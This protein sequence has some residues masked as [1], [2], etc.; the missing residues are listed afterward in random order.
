MI[1]LVS[2]RNLRSEACTRIS[3][4]RPGLLLRLPCL[5]GLFQRPANL[6]E[7]FGSESKAS[8]FESS[9]ARRGIVLERTLIPAG[10]CL[11]LCYMK[12]FSNKRGKK[13]NSMWP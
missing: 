10:Y 1:E 2:A 3:G 9:K 12:M 5:N 13:A 7:G 11:S 8:M 4:L 6:E